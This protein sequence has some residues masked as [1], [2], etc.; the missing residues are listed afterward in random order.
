VHSLLVCHL[1]PIPLL[2]LV[3]INL[4]LLLLLLLY[5]LRLLLLL[6]LPLQAV[7]CGSASRRAGSCLATYH[8][9]CACGCS[10]LCHCQ[11]VWQLRGQ[12]FLLCPPLLAWWTRLLLGLGTLLLPLLVLVVL[13]P[14]SLLLLHLGGSRWCL[15]RCCPS[16]TLLPPAFLL[17]L[18]LPLLPLLLVEW[19]PHLR[20]IHLP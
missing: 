4:L 15:L 7:E 5:I 20:F 8:V 14:T 18:P 9:H 11:P 1:L 3:P 17:L 6:L 12:G 10:G 2:L 16:K 19:L 13:P